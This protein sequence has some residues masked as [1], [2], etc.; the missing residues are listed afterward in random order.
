MNRRWIRFAV[1]LLSA[2]TVACAV[3]YG[4]FFTGDPTPVVDSRAVGSQTAPNAPVPEKIQP[5]PALALAELSPDG[6]VLRVESLVLD[7]ARKGMLDFNA[8]R[9][10]YDLVALLPESRIEA[11]L[12]F[13][14]KKLPQNLFLD[15]G[16]ILLARLSEGDA[17]WALRLAGEIKD[18][19]MRAQEMSK[20]LKSLAKTDIKATVTW[21]A[22]MP[23]GLQKDALLADLLPSLAWRDPARALALWK[24]QGSP[25]FDRNQETLSKILRSYASKNLSAAVAEAESLARAHG[26]RRLLAA[27]LANQAALALRAGEVEPAGRYLE[28]AVDLDRATENL[29]GLAHDL[30]L[31]AR[32][33]Q[34]QGN[35]SDALELEQRAKTILQ[36]T[37][38]HHWADRREREVGSAERKSGVRSLQAGLKSDEQDGAPV[39]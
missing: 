37:G 35:A 34:R 36:H 10:L 32:V 11:L 17:V 22:S 27:A 15:V 39:E 9:D 19:N 8:R 23:M 12:K 29:P 16:G 21:L 31:L 26:D 3:W 20:A 1:L 33:R 5:K 4:V 24:S 30:L 2:G 28:E 38:Q 13:A 25:S 6:L 18:G 14:Q 7:I